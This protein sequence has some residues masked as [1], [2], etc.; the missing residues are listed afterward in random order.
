MSDPKDRVVR[1]KRKKTGPRRERK[2]RDL[3]A[4]IRR[5]A[6]IVSTWPEWKRGGSAARVKEQTE[7]KVL[8]K[9]Q[10]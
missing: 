5:V 1:M 7:L 3:R 8:P 10:S 6:E 2:A 9:R 4:N